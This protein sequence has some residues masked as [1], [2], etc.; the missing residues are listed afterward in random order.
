MT[1]KDK[2]V[3]YWA[4]RFGLVPSHDD[5]EECEVL[6]STPLSEVAQATVEDWTEVDPD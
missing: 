1:E 5:F 3:L 4:R 6:S 2:D